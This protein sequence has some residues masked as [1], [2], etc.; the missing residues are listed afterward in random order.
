MLNRHIL[1]LIFCF[2]GLFLIVYSAYSLGDFSEYGAAFM[3]SII[4]GGIIIFS[5]I[6]IF[7]RKQETDTPLV[8]WHEI[9]FV[10]LIIGVILFYVLAADYLGFILT[11]LI[12][13]A[14]LMM[15]YAK[16]K[17]IY[18]FIISASVVLGVYYLFT[19]VLLVPLPQ[20]FS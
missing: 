16:L 8:T 11:G 1:S 7:S 20:L 5:L 2:F 10:L 15:K 9:K 18:S 14:P 13:T 19:A 12:I 6:D 4:G 3:P 17:Y